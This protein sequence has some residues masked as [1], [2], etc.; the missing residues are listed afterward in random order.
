M[1]WHDSAAGEWYD[2]A[3]QPSASAEVNFTVASFNMV[4]AE[5]GALLF[6]KRELSCKQYC[7]VGYT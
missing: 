1:Q 7:T 5:T 3:W 4:T 2:S 6:R